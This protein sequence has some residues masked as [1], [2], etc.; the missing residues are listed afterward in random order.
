MWHGSKRCMILVSFFNLEHGSSAPCAVSV[1]FSREFPH[2]R[3]FKSLEVDYMSS[4]NE[5][6]PDFTG[7][8]ASGGAGV[9]S[10]FL[11]ITGPGGGVDEPRRTHCSVLFCSR[12]DVSSCI[13]ARNGMDLVR[14]PT[15][16]LALVMKPI[17]ATS[18]LSKGSRAAI[19]AMIKRRS[20]D[21]AD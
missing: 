17:S 18:F 13:M 2:F 20:V 16:F 10:W 11:L 14:A 5:L 9:G 7:R 4:F 6:E 3:D 15:I 21:E 19:K 12:C 8:L 1:S